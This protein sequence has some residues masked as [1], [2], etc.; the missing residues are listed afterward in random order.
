MIDAANASAGLA[1]DVQGLGDLRL[2]A[3]NDPDAAL[4]GAA[5]QFEALFMQML[6]KSMRDTVDQD[7]LFD[8]EQTRQFTLMLGSA[9]VADTGRQGP[10]LGRYPGHRSCSRRRRQCRRWR[11]P[12]RMP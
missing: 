12:A 8:S 5:R 4:K 9:V 1:I 2:K 3:K 6:L 11:F 10:G 7:G